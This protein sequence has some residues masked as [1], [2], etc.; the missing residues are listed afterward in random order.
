M[1]FE[2]RGIPQAIINHCQRIADE[3]DCDT[4]IL[5]DLLDAIVD[6]VDAVKAGVARPADNDHGQA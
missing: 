3:S 2:Y 4:A 6:Y 5:D 1:A